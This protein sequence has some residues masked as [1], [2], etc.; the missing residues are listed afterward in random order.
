M[1]NPHRRTFSMFSRLL[2]CLGVLVG[3]GRAAD[4]QGPGPR[5]DLIYPPGGQAG[6]AFEVRVS[7]SALDGLSGLVFDD[8]RITATALGDR[9][10]TVRFPKDVPPGLHDVRARGERGLS[11]PRAIFVSP[12][13]TASADEAAGDSQEVKLDVSL[14]GLIETP[15]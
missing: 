13:E 1:I 5:L 8:S 9:R 4:A 7:G 6:T 11:A 12:R 14:C 2:A 15:G 3:L 10:F